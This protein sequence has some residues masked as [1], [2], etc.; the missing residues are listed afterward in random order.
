MDEKGMRM[1]YGR[2]SAMAVIA[3]VVAGCGSAAWAEAPQ[4]GEQPSELIIRNAIIVNGNGTP[5]EGPVDIRIR[6]GVIDRI[7]PFRASTSSE[8]RAKVIDAGGHYVLPGFINM[9]AHIHD[10]QA[11]RPIPFE[12]IYK[13]WLASGITTVRDVGSNLEKTLEERDRSAR[14]FI[15]APRIFLNF[16]F[17]SSPELRAL[18][19]V[20]SATEDQLRE[21]VRW[22]KRRGADGIKLRALDRRTV[23][24]VLDEAKRQGLPVAH[25]IGVEDANVLDNAE[26]G[27]A[28][29]EHWYGIPDAALSGLQP[30][31][32]DF[33][34]S[35]ELDRF[36]YAGRLWREVK[37]NKL[38]TVLQAMVDGGVAWNPTFAIYEACR[39]LQRATTQPAFRD[40]LHPSLEQFFAP[41]P[42]YHGS[43]F[44]GWTNTDEVYWK[45]NFRLWM[46]AVHRFA[47][48]G[49][50]VTTGE[51]AGYIYQLYGFCYLRELQL[52]EEAGFSPLEVIRNA[53][54]NGARVLG[55]EERLGRI[56]PGYAADLVVV[57]GNPLENLQILMPKGLE[58]VLDEQRHGLGGIEWTIK[59]GRAYHAPTL[60]EEV[61]DLVDAANGATR[62]GF[63]SALD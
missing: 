41:N 19:N 47:E 22:M 3:V 4:H 35:N 14:G 18:G 13:L 23:R 61:R 11:G 6:D 12:Y 8:S 2:T 33:N 57:N 55:E 56:Q 40:Y 62:E 45:E 50:L 36:R 43:F 30:F 52:Q 32:A 21:E 58:P 10:R 7:L 24:I 44:F 25:H 51:D 16:W 29:I 5:A 49:G 15:A 1:K 38:D 31:P 26:L 17:P 46:D 60:L 39:D 9:H 54:W 63:L 53:T 34:H 27:T 37:P 28:T 48:L 59:D 42:D 20:E